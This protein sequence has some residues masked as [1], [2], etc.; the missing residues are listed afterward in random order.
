MCCNDVMFQLVPLGEEEVAW[1][2]R[3][4]LPLHEGSNIPMAELPC[5]L[6]VNGRCTDYE[7]RPDTCRK[8]RC[9]LLRALEAGEVTLE[10]GL[11]KVQ[12]VKSLAMRMLPN[13]RSAVDAASLTPEHLLEFGELEALLT[14][15][16]RD[17][18]RKQSLERRES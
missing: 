13:G 10:Q 12:R 6:L 18:D 16:F 15:H 7:H 17:P 5:Q 1:A 9:F 3:H 8:Y 4:R 14:R 11:A 2:K